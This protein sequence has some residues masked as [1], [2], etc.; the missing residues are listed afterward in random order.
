MQSYLVGN[1]PGL[2]NKSDNSDSEGQIE[3][4]LRFSVNKESL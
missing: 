3:I 2:S 1:L 4:T